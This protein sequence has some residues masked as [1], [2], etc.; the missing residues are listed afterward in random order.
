MRGFFRM[1]AGSDNGL[2]LIFVFI[3]LVIPNISR[4]HNVKKQYFREDDIVSYTKQTWRQIVILLVILN[5]G[6]KSTPT[7]TRN[8][9]P[10]KHFRL[11]YR[12]DINNEYFYVSL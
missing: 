1:W 9:P 12:T 10:K 4:T 6:C 7:Q 3:A 5:N 8:N 2:T 11:F